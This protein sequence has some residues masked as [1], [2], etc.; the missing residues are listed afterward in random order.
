MKRNRAQIVGDEMQKV[1]SDIIMNK[2]R[3]PRIPILTSVTEVK[4]SSDLTHA[5]VY[6]SVFGDNE[7]CD[8]AMKAIE[9]AKGFIRTETVKQIK[10]RLA[11]ELHFKLDTMLE[12]ATR[13]DKLIDET[14]KKDEEIRKRHSGEA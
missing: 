11:P 5:T 9:H 3:D 7:V 6:I 8:N 12:E 4:M 13:M 10:L 14:I 2:L 1:I